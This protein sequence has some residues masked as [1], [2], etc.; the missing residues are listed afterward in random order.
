MQIRVLTPLFVTLVCLLIGCAPPEE[1]IQLTAEQKIEQINEWLPDLKMELAMEGK[2][3][4]C[5]KEGC[6]QCILAHGSCPCYNNLQ[7]GRPV[8]GDCY[9]GWQL[10]HGIDNDFTIDDV[11]LD[12][13]HSH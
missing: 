3:A 10:G 2:Y 4:C 5:L 8:C 12:T 13:D 1:E 11:K 9:S 6:N 7:E